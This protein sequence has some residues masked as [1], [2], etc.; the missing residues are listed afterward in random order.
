MTFTY[1]LDMNVHGM[2]IWKM[3]TLAEYLSEKEITDEAFAA[4]VGVSR[5]M[6]TKLRN[7]TAKPSADTAL[8]I[9]AITGPSVGLA[10]LMPPPHMA[11]EAEQSA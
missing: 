5:S 9:M 11:A 6:V 1:V 7:R 2:H 3:T 10:D 8:R 4:L